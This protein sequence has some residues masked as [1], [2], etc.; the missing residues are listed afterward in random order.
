MSKR[1]SSYGGATKKA[2]A[3]FKTSWL[4]ELIETQTVDSK[5]PKRVELGSIFLYTESAGVVCKICAEAESTCDFAVGKFWDQWKLDY[6][7]RH[8]VQNVHSDSLAKLKR[9]KSGSSTNFL[10]IAYFNIKL[11]Q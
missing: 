8:I 2:A 7:K 11:A 9:M 6:L 5:I 1:K 10:L 4:N 3:S